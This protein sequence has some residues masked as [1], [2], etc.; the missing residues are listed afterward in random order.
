MEFK[1][2][3][4]TD[5]A[6]SP[7]IEFSAEDSLAS[8]EQAVI[9]AT[10]LKSLA[11]TATNL[12]DELDSLQQPSITALD[13]AKEDQGSGRVGSSSTPPIDTDKPIPPNLPPPPS[14]KPLTNEEFLALLKNFK[15]FLIWLAAH[16]SNLNG[17]VALLDWLTTLGT[18]PLSPEQT[19]ELNK[20]MAALTTT[21]KDGNKV[22]LDL[23][24][25][26]INLIVKLSAYGDGTEQ[27]YEELQAAAQRTLQDLQKSFYRISQTN[28]GLEGWF[29]GAKDELDKMAEFIN[30]SIG[31]FINWINPNGVDFKDLQGVKFGFLLMMEKSLG[32]SL[33]SSSMKDVINEFY[34]F[35]RDELKKKA[36][37]SG[38]NGLFLQLMVLLLLDRAND[39][40]SSLGGLG[41]LLEQI[42][43][44]LTLINDISKLFSEGM[45]G[46]FTE[47]SAQQLIQ[48][49]QELKLFISN[50]AGFAAVSDG[51]IANINKILG[52]RPD[53]ATGKS[54]GTGHS[55]E[56][57]YSVGD[58]TQ[59]KDLLNALF[60]KRMNPP[61]DNLPE[62][63]NEQALLN[64]Q[65]F[66]KIFSSIRTSLI[67][68]SQTT[69]SE[70]QQSQAKNQ[71]FLGAIKA[72]LDGL[73]NII[74]TMTNNLKP[75]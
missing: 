55:I 57:V 3:Q 50:N 53:P 24:S 33:K 19:A 2:I 39:T 12:I 40:D 5:V 10:L 22:P 17:A 61:K 63:E 43:K 37:Q 34:Q 16:P 20:M 18:A 68:F 72:L 13:L 29:K 47:E 25:L 67:N 46:T 41:E 27:T 36:D 54:S 21:D 56:E 64:R 38:N 44:Y 59:L 62:S 51:I 31:D 8:I 7:G 65:E 35:Y 26:I 74:K 52:M 48:K 49:L 6:N 15:D 75:A 70:L 23:G 1:N 11:S 60:Q 28:P 9:S 66:E 69:S 30:A 14:D 58:F 4:T 45:D 32:G 71:T 42:G 73:A